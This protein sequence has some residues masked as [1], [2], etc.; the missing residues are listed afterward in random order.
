MHAFIQS[1]NISMYV[2]GKPIH[3]NIM[4]RHFEKSVKL[5]KNVILHVGGID[6]LSLTDLGCVLL[7]YRVQS[8]LKVTMLHQY[9][10]FFFTCAVM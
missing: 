10:Y 8:A 3:V 1:F 6:L 9:A 7:F 5:I 2:N 4:N